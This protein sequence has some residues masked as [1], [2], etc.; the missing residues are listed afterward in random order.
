MSYRAADRNRSTYLL[1]NRNISAAVLC[2]HPSDKADVEFRPDLVMETG[3]DP[4]QGRRLRLKPNGQCEVAGCSPKGDAQ[5]DTTQR[6]W[7]KDCP[8]AG[9]Q[10]ALQNVLHKRRKDV[11]CDLK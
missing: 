7:W 2:K 1:Q 5:R 9:S 10:S 8:K 4:T 11:R 6:R 3:H